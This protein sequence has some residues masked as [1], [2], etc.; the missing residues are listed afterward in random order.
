MVTG[1]TEIE[2]A[3]PFLIGNLPWMLIYAVGFIA[4]MFLLTGVQKSVLSAYDAEDEAA[5][6]AW[7]RDAGN[8]DGRLGP[9]ARRAP[10]TDEPPSLVLL[11]DHFPAVVVSILVFYTCMFGFTMFIGKGMARGR[12]QEAKAH[13]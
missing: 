13:T 4:I 8:K 12:T 2:P 11:R 1:E 7:K 5:W 3:T 9:I 6:L 10:A